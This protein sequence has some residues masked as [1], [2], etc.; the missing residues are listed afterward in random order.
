M[1]TSPTTT[2]SKPTGDAKISKGIF[3]YL[4]TLNRQRAYDLVVREFKKSG[5]SG[6]DLSRRMGRAPEVISRL[7]NRPGNWEADTFSDLM[8]AI[9]GAVPKYEAEYPLDR[10]KTSEASPVVTG[11]TNVFPLDQHLKKTGTNQ[12]QTIAA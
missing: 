5:L 8:F 11:T 12:L 3:G 2:L 6:A 1:S 9:S 4:R 7:L 10:P